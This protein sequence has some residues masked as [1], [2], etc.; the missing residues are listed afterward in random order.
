VDDP[1]P[2]YFTKF[3]GKKKSNW[4][5]RLVSKGRNVNKTRKKKKKGE[6]RRPT[7]QSTGKKKKKLEEEA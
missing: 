4:V 7:N 3:R 5:R 6:E 1:Q 2:T